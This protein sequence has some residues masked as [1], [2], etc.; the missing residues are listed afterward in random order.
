[1]SPDQV[2]KRRTWQH[3]PIAS[4]E[5]GQ[6]GAEVI[7]GWYKISPIDGIEVTTSGRFSEFELIATPRHS[8]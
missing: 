8:E 3:R 6:L 1:M 7:V 5:N 2:G 4:A